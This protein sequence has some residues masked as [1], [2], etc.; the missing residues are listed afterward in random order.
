MEL[1]L[2]PK[3]STCSKRALTRRH[4][5]GSQRHASGELAVY[6]PRGALLDRLSQETGMDRGAV[7]RQL[8]AERE[9]LLS[10]GQV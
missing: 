3:L 2:Y 1:K 4:Y 8:F 6:T 5:R 10:L 7:V 9:Y